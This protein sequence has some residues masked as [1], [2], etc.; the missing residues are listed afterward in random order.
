MSSDLS[1]PAVAAAPAAEHRRMHPIALLATLAA[2]VVPVMSVFSV[3]VALR[4]I[5]TELGASAGTLQLVVAAY[6]VVYAALVVI[7]GRLGDSFGRKRMLLVGLGMF[8]VTSL[9][10]AVAQTPGQLVAARFLQ[11]LSAAA[12]SPQVLA[13]IHANSEGHHRTRALGWFAATAGLSTSLAFLVGGSL[14]GSDLGWRSV[15]WINT[16]VALLV[17]IGV[18]RYLPETKAPARTSLDWVGAVLLG[19]TMTLLI[20]PLTEGRA[21]GWPLWTWVC[22]VAAPVALAALVWWQVRLQRRGGLP[23]LPPELFAFRT[24]RIGLLVAAPVFVTF[25]GFMFV[26]AFMAGSHGLSPLRI[27]LSLLPMSLGF[28]GASLA[29]GRLM[30][31]FGVGVL[32]AGGALT[33]GGLVW[34]GLVVDGFAATEVYSA[35]RVAAPM[36]VVGVGMAL[37]WSPLMGVILSQVHGHLAGLGGGL[38]LTVMQASLGFGSAV[39]GSVY[40]GLR[41]DHAFQWTAFV[42]AAV[43]VV[44]LPLTQL[45]RPR[46]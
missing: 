8:A 10:C 19:A 2:A 17:M 43:M 44:V 24:V 4:Q 41:A 11:G 37:L 36:V 29:T 21:T 22:L 40:F 32:A 1:S 9:L 28:L 5:G 25:G 14:A 23:L 12:L 26:Y 30:A 35:W 31:R 42:L 45:L 34:V 7:G 18:V 3:N 33:A 16:P 46:T 13:S 38:L 6:G 27:G 20:F 39:V 15:F